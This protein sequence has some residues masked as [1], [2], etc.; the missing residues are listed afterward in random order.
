[1]KNLT[2]IFGTLFFIWL[3]YIMAGGNP[4]VLIQ[5]PEFTICFFPPLLFCWAFTPKGT[6]KLTLKAVFSNA[7]K[8]EEI[9]K[10]LICKCLNVFAIVS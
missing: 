2:A 6:L 5:I 1:M 10:K 9:E 8:I 3:G 7:E 4:L